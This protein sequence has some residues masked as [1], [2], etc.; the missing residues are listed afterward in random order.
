MIAVGYRLSVQLHLDHIPHRQ[1][2]SFVAALIVT[3]VAWNVLRL[4]LLAAAKH[5]LEKAK[6]RLRE[7]QK[8]QQ[9]EGE[10]RKGAHV[11]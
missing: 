4:A 5:L 11:V 8:G 10:E 1:L 2:T 7:A 9:R 6:I 3:R